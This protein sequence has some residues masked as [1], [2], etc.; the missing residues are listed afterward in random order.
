MTGPG[1]TIV[2][3]SDHRGF[4]VID[5][6]RDH[7]ATKGW[8]VEVAV[9]P[10]GDDP[11]VDY[12]DPAAEVASAVR[13]GRAAR[14][15]L[16]CGSGIGM[17]IAANKIQGVRAALVHD[18]TG[19]EMSRRHNDANVLCMGADVV[20]TP[21]METLIDLWLET[22]FEGG[23]HAGRVDKISGLEAVT[24]SST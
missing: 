6:I 16:V 8:T 13:D 5:T 20:D 4:E 7:L 23:R 14:G 1:K 12:P 17:S 19:A 10:C 3:G 21:T 22:G 24:D 11:K 18:A 2:I 9:R 15:I